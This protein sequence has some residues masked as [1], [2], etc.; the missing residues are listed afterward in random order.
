MSPMRCVRCGTMLDWPADFP[1]RIYA[2]CTACVSWEHAEALRRNSKGLFYLVTA[3]VGAL[4]LAATIY[5]F[6]VFR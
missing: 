2:I 6:E 1:H 3:A 5:Y 4:A